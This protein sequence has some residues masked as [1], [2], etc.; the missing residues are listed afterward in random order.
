MSVIDRFYDRTSA[1]RLVPR[2]S[3]TLQERGRRR[4]QVLIYQHGLPKPKQ[5]SSSRP[6]TIRNSVSRVDLATARDA[7][8]EQWNDQE[9]SFIRFS[10]LYLG[11]PTFNEP[12]SDSLSCR[13]SAG[14]EAMTP[15]NNP[16]RFPLRGPLVS[17]PHSHLSH[18]QALAPL[19]TPLASTSWR[20]GAS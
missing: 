3:M 4:L 20:I 2:L 1:S 19:A 5:S 10:F 13:F 11:I 9:K 12:H 8:K 7:G 6:G 17:F 15:I 18:Q 16:L 14:N